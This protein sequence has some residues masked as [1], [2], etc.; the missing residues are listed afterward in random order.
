MKV[1]Q[2]QK[3]PRRFDLLGVKL[4]FYAGLLRKRGS[5]FINSQTQLI[6]PFGH[7][8]KSPSISF[9]TPIFPLLY[10]TFTAYSGDTLNQLLA[11]PANVQ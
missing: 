3:K 11:N 10:S 9:A 4:F 2:C 1:A 8:Q 6:V 5:G 7:D